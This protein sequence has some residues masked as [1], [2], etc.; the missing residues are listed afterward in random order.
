MF[1]GSVKKEIAPAR[2]GSMST[3]L[4]VTPR[5]LN[6]LDRGTHDPASKTDNY[7]SSLLLKE[8]QVRIIMI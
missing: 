4:Y 1:V 7:T 3:L 6:S 5:L 2:G 8:C